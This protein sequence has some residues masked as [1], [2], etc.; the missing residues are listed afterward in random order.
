LR[1]WFF[2]CFGPRADLPAGRLGLSPALK[3]D[4]SP[5]MTLRAR[6]LGPSPRSVDYLI[7]GL[8]I[9]LVIVGLVVYA[10]PFFLIG[11]MITLAVGFPA[12]AALTVF[13]IAVIAV[14]FLSCVFASK[15]TR[16]SGA[17]LRTARPGPGVRTRPRFAW[18]DNAARTADDYSNEKRLG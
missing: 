18:P 7:H 6:N 13:P 1:R 9:L 4:K 17:G 3:H 15:F 14:L 12:W 5:F 10:M 16:W 11:M 2:G 8:W